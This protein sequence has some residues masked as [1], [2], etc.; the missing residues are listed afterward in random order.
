MSNSNNYALIMAGGVGSRFWPWS[1]SSRPKQFLDILNTGKTLIGQTFDRLRRVCPAKNI[2]VVTNENYKQDIIHL[3]PEIPEKNILLEPRMRNTAP[4]IAYGAHKILKENP[5]ARIIV[6]PSDHLVLKEDIFAGVVEAGLEYASQ[7][8]SL[9]TMGI[10]PHRPETGYGYIQADTDNLE[11]EEIN[12]RLYP[13]S[14]FTEKPDRQT[15]EKFLK[16]GNYFWNSG[17]FIWSAN[18]I[19]DAFDEHLPEMNKLFKKHLP[20]FNTNHETRAIEEIYKNCQ[21]ISIDYG[22]MEKASNVKVLCTDFGWS[23]IGTWGSLYEH[24]E[25]D[26]H[27]NA[28]RGDKIIIEDTENSVIKIP[29]HK[30]AVIQGLDEHIVVDDDNALLI[31]RKKDEQRI[32]DYVKKVKKDF[33]PDYA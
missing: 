16:E 15:A 22:I 19:L 21:T 8:N 27:K 26:S 31:C 9:L 5:Q 20:E 25:W 3:L 7:H 23:D 29:D 10:Q 32:R 4:C 13:V 18:V 1:R 17:V 30:V 11:K 33:G 2:M 28:L 24:S 6:A 12:Y 14:R